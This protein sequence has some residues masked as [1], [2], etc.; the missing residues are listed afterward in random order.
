H[1][2]RRREASRAEE[3][4][5]ERARRIPPLLLAVDQPVAREHA[6]DRRPGR[7]HESLTRRSLGCPGGV[8]ERDERDEPREEQRRY[9]GDPHDTRCRGYA[10]RG[11]GSRAPR[12]PAH[13]HDREPERPEE[14]GHENAA[15]SLGRIS[16][17][18]AASARGAA[19]PTE[20]GRART[21]PSRPDG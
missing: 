12:A 2:P 17:S 21:P 5:R 9:A 13:P 10:P 6:Q 16:R 19:P 11:D 1:H 14:S 7:Q 4:P 3:P 8:Q 20:P 18:R 15:P